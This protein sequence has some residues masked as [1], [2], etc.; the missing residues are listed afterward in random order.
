MDTILKRRSIRNFTNEP[1][2]KDVIK[3][4][5][6]AGM[7]APSAFN[8]QPWEFIV[9]NRQGDKDAIAKASPYAGCTKDAAYAIIVLCTSER[10]KKAHTW[11]IQ[12]L[13]A[14]TENMLLTIADENLAGVWLGMYPDDDRVNSLQEYFKIDK[15]QI[16]FAVIAIGHSEEANKFVDRYDASK[17][18]W[19]ER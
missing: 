9:T 3:K 5:I 18:N 13:S 1:V 10:A 15:N 4:I 6:Q 7:Q 2:S 19:R 8:A 14:A 17:V 11:W 16:P 12:D